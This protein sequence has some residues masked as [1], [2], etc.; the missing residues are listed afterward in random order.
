MAGKKKKRE[1]AISNSKIRKTNRLQGKKYQTQDGKEIPGKVFTNKK[2]KC[3]SKCYL[4]ISSERRKN[5]YEHYH[6]FEDSVRQKLFLYTMLTFKDPVRRRPRGTENSKPKGVIIDYHLRSFDPD[7]NFDFK[8]CSKFFCDTFG[9][10]VRT[11]I[12]WANIRNPADME[13]KLKSRTSL[14]K[15]DDSDVKNFLDNIKLYDS[16][17]SREKNHDKKYLPPNYTIAKL[18]NDYLDDCK[19]RECEP[20]VNERKFYEIIQFETNISIH[21][22]LQ[23]TCCTCDKLKVAID[24]EK[25]TR[26]RQQLIKEKEDHWKEVDEAKA[27]FD[28]DKEEANDGCLVITFDLQKALP[29]P[30]LTTG[31]AYYKRNFY[32]YNFGIHQFPE[33]KDDFMFLW[34]EN[35]ASRGAVEISSCLVS[36][37]R[38]YAGSARH[39]ISFSDRCGGQNRNIKTVLALLR[40]LHDPTIKIEKID[41]KY[42]VSGHSRLPNDSDFG[43]IENKIRERTEIFSKEDYYDIITESRVKQFVIRKM[44]HEDFLSIDQLLSAITN[45]KKTLEGK[46]VNWLKFCWIRLEKN[47]PFEIQFKEKFSDSSFQTI[48]IKKKGSKLNNLFEIIPQIEYESERPITEAKKKDLTDLLPF[49]PLQYR[50]FFLNLKTSALA[51][52]EN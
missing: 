35:E 9:L 12:R 19:V 46:S 37:L 41:M 43:L 33:E 31:Q 4:K 28:G 34:T 39:I 11:V 29:L 36:F 32:L 27:V 14:K 21:T 49:I 42:L 13:H 22:P 30:V 18:Y 47:R 3:L 40:L 2:C 6:N 7:I 16:H 23:D 17:Y 50:Q 48:N 15:I 44:M 24:H 8:V 52:D 38:Q 26:K 51:V 45:R 25:N 20:A 10:N 1:R 5:L